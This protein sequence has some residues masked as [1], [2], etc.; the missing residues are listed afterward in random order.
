MGKVSIRFLCAWKFR[1]RPNIES[2]TFLQLFAWISYYV[3]DGTYVGD[4]DY[5]TAILSGEVAQVVPEPS[6]LVILGVGAISLIG[7]ALRRR[8]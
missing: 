4:N 3:P 7:F 5:G 2:T 1:R 6:S 8:R